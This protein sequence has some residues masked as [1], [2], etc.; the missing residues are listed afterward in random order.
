MGWRR[1]RG[2]AGPGTWGCRAA[3]GLGTRS[4]CG[5]TKG[6][7]PAGLRQT[8]PPGSSW[9]RIEDQSPSPRVVLPVGRCIHTCVHTH[10][11]LTPAHML[12]QTHTFTHSLTHFGS[13]RGGL[14]GASSHRCCLIASCQPVL[15][16]RLCADVLCWE[17]IR[18]PHLQ[19]PQ[20]TLN[21]GVQ[22][23]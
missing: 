11:T 4:P 14:Q 19:G 20:T 1:W 15:V 21:S 5:L 17:L 2:K 12:S 22:M 18:C 16:E 9:T 10:S 3:V 13:D 8:H 6:S 7:G 23:S